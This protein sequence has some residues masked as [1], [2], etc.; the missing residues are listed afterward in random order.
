MVSNIGAIAAVIAATNNLHKQK[1]EKE[2]QEQKKRQIDNSFKQVIQDIYIKS[3]ESN[4]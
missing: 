3:E 2:K 1:Q 4:R